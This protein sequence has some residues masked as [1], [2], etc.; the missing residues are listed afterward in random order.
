[1]CEVCGPCGGD[2]LV[3]NYKLLMNELKRE[4]REKLQSEEQ[5]NKLK[6]YREKYENKYTNAA[7]MFFGTLIPLYL[8]TFGALFIFMFFF[9]PF[10]LII[11]PGIGW[12][13]PLIHGAIWVAAVISV[14]RKRSVLEDIIQRF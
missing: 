10:L 12:M 4:L 1:M 8:L 5:K 6:A 3:R 9:G 2:P 14:Y 7:I 11:D 13:L